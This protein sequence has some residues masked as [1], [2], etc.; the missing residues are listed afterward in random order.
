MPIIANNETI[1]PFFS[2][3]MNFVRGLDPLGLQNTS[4][5]T[6]AMLLPGLNNVTGRIRYYS[7]YC[8]LLHEYAKRVGNTNPDEQRKF[9]R[10]A[11]LIVALVN[12]SSDE[13]VSAIPGSNYAN[14]L[15]SDE[16]ISTYDLQNATYKPD[17]TTE[18]TYWKYASGAF[19]QYYLGSLLDIGLII[20][21][22]KGGGVY[23]RTPRKEGVAVSGEDLALDFEMNI[24][25]R[26]RELFFACIKKGKIKDSELADL[27]D[28]FN[29]SFVPKGSKES[30]HL[31]TLL[32]EKDFPQRLE[33]APVTFRRTTIKHLLQFSSDKGDVSDRQFTV[34]SYD[35]KGKH[36][37]KEDECLIGWYYYQLNE[38]WQ[39]ACLG[40]FNGTIDYLEKVAG[41]S[42]KNM[43]QLV[44][45]ISDIVIKQLVEDEIIISGKQKMEHVFRDAD[46]WIEES[47]IFKMISETRLTDRISNSIF[48]I[49]CLVHRNKANINRLKTYGVNNEIEKDGDGITFCLKFEKYFDLTVKEF[50]KEILLTH[51]IYRHQFVAFRK[52]GTGIQSTQLCLIEEGKIRRLLNFEPSLTG[53]RIGRLLG[54]LHDLGILQN[55]K[56]TSEGKS[57]LKEL[58][59]ESNRQT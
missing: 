40:V 12:R 50:L 58:S 18:G 23:S 43:F 56:L 57:L 32:L 59:G 55:Q 44:E 41:S 8:W 3:P 11:E 37:K 5:A 1:V 27:F 29:L 13:E 17:G 33:E 19:G 38:Y 10:R 24:S 15:L 7:F 16:S 45:E 4:E 31:T 49:L 54:F 35:T 51:I 22:E 6:F 39:Y 2:R 21:R 34:Y 42:W 36:G 53:P 46:D 20:E 25:Q 52:M 30:K 9:I 47:E 26:N 48:L 14:K 28:E